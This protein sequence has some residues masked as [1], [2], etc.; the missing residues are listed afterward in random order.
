LKYN[1][2]PGSKLK[3]GARRLAGEA[4]RAVRPGPL[5]PKKKRLLGSPIPMVKMPRSFSSWVR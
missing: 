2:H 4:N 3:A 5:L 1:R